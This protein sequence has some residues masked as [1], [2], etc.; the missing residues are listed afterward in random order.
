ML[1][2]RLVFRNE[3]VL[4]YATSIIASKGAYVLD[5]L[6]NILA[7]TLDYIEGRVT[8]PAETQDSLMCWTCILDASSPNKQHLKPSRKPIH[9]VLS[10]KD[11]T[12]IEPID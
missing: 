6:D 12:L 5:S 1:S 4:T 11:I 2:C 9:R 8:L 10:G 3:L 7:Y